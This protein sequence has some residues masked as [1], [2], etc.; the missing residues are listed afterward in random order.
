MMSTSL[1]ISILFFHFHSS[2]QQVPS[3]CLWFERLDLNSTPIVITYYSSCSNQQRAAEDRNWC[4]FFYLIRHPS[5][6]EPLKVHRFPINSD[7]RRG[8]KKN[9]C[10]NPVQAVEPRP[11]I[12]NLQKVIHVKI[13][14][15]WSSDQMVGGSISL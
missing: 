2:F 3:I 12:S 14:R 4:F 6:F 7:R 10:D 15:T 5:S 1:A 11:I 13:M 8:M 9:N